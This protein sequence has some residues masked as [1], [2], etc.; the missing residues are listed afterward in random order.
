MRDISRHE[1]CAFSQSVAVSRVSE[2]S[3]PKI[4]F[5]PL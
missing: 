5:G 1:R 2:L 4:M 3:E